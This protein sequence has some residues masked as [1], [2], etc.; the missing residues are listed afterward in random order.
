[1][2]Q[3]VLLK[4][5]QVYLLSLM[6]KCLDLER[7]FVECYNI[8]LLSLIK[9]HVCLDLKRRSVERGLIFLSLTQLTSLDLDYKFVQHEAKF[10]SRILHFAFCN[11]P[12]LKRPPQMSEASVFPYGR[13]SLT[14]VSIQLQ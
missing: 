14:R 5:T 4:L 1:M 3:V 2:K 11:F 9:I 6:E 12:Y 10:A 13:W 8:I 7:K